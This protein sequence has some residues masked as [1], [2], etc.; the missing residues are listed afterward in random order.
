[1][2]FLKDWLQTN[3]LVGNSF[4]KAV[5]AGAV[6]VDASVRELAFG[7]LAACRHPQL[8][9]LAFEQLQN[10][11]PQIRL[12]GLEHLRK[13]KPAHGL[14]A[15]ILLLDDPDLTV[16]AS[17]GIALWRWTGQDFGIRIARAIQ[18]KDNL[19]RELGNSS[20]LASFRTGIQKWK[21]W[22]TVHRS[23]FPP[24]EIPQLNNPPEPRLRVS[25]FKLRDLTGS[26]V[27]LSDF[28]GKTVLLNFWTTWCTACLGEFS[29][30][31]ELQRKHADE[32]VILGISLD[33]VP[34]EHGHIPSAGETHGDEDGKEHR[35]SLGEL[36]KQ[37]QRVAKQRG[38]AYRLLLDPKN[39]VGARFNGG[40]LPTNV[41]IDSTGHVR[42]RFI[43]PRT[44]A[45]FE[46]MISEVA[47]IPRAQSR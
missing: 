44:I 16:A 9:S 27:Y 35:P 29:V 4:E 41:L 22:W 42:R 2:S 31:N 12:L 14:P 43:G 20:D 30:L 28:K 37:V 45:V 7:I 47:S 33:G 8:R 39:E 21:D 25:D 23:D 1:M 34:D 40:E 26:S 46:A 24:L 11:D 13:E 6:D 38:I 3:A 19:G 17:A 10:A 32:L 18:T 36:R 5:L 15:V